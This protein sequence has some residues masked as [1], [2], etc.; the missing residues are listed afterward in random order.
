MRSLVASSSRTTL[1]HSV[2][3]WRGPPGSG[4]CKVD[5]LAKSSRK[6]SVCLR[7]NMTGHLDLPCRSGL[8]VLERV[9][10]AAF[11]GHLRN[12]RNGVAS[13]SQSAR[14]YHGPPI[15]SECLSY[16]LFL[17]AYKRS[18]G[19]YLPTPKSPPVET[20]D[21][22]SALHTP[23]ADAL[24]MALCR[25]SVPLQRSA[26]RF[27]CLSTTLAAQETRL[28]EGRFCLSSY[29]LLLC[30]KSHGDCFHTVMVD[31]IRISASTNP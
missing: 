6:Q 2:V 16:F 23:P 25:P 17:V 15:T 31:T 30:G 11:G 4:R 9:A 24:F 28:C 1:V 29:R 14:S 18:Y 12:R 7:S 13:S 19:C 3:S 21:N 8:S 26:E 27:G 20:M 5:N 22:A 10:N